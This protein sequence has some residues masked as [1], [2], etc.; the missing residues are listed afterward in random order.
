M[1]QL[2]IGLTEI[3]RQERKHHTI[4]PYNISTMLKTKNKMHDHEITVT[5]TLHI[6]HVLL[7]QFIWIGTQVYSFICLDKDVFSGK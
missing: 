1:R 4:I 2:P 7:Y 3:I 6:V 5:L